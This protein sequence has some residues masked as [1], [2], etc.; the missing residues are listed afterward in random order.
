[1]IIL[2]LSIFLFLI[3][4]VGYGKIFIKINNL[5]DINLSFGETGLLGLFF[6]TFLGISLHFFF[7]LNQ[8]LNTFIFLIGISFF[9]YE[10]STSKTKINFK[11]IFK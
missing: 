2:I 11:Q 3:S 8:K 4:V 6:I 5:N 9:L 10:I 1:M 7:P